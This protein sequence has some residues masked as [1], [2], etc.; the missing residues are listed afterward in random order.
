M[1]LVGA[2][3][4]TWRLC[5]TLYQGVLLL[6][7]EIQLERGGFKVCQEGLTSLGPCHLMSESH[8]SE[9]CVQAEEMEKHN[10]TLATHAS[11]IEGQHTAMLQQMA[12]YNARLQATAS[13]N[14]ALQREIAQ[15]RA[16]VEVGVCY[17]LAACSH[18]VPVV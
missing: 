8:W 16:L 6:L 10:N 12:E 3:R 17:P 9:M 14:D 7:V 1:R 4:G 11:A 15:L 2:R 13:Q 18:T 5:W